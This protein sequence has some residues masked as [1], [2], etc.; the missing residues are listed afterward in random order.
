MVLGIKKLRKLL[1]FENKIIT[2]SELKN[3]NIVRKSLVAAKN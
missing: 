3:K 2:K 1:G